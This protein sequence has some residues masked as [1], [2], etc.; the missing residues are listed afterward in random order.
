MR[1]RRQHIPVAAWKLLQTR[2]L[3]IS[4]LDWAWEIKT[5]VGRK[6][7]LIRLLQIKSIVSEAK[8]KLM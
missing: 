7:R 5:M 8:F 4:R 1:T 6:V 3:R 2:T